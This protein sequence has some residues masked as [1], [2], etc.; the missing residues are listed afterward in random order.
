[1]E[2]STKSKGSLTSRVITAGSWTMAGYAIGQFLRLGSNLIMT[3]LL[4]PEMFGLLALTQVFLYIVGLISD[5]GIKPS[6]ITSKRGEEPAF[7]N[8]AWTI[9]IIRGFFMMGG[10]IL[11][12]LIIAYLT[13]V[14]FFVEGSVYANEDFPLILSVMSVTLLIGGFNS[15][16]IYLA[17]RKLQLGRLTIIGLVSQVAGLAIM[18]GWALYDRSVWA[19]VA[20]A[21]STAIIFTTLTHFGFSGG[22]SRFH[23][24]WDAFWEIFHFGKWI[25]VSSV[26]TAFY[27]QGD[28]LF[29]GLVISA[30]MMGVYGIAFFLSSSFQGILDKIN[31]MVFFPMFSEIARVNSEKLVEYYYKVRLRTDSLAFICAGGLF[32][33]AETLIYVLYDARYHDA[34]W[35]LQ[36]L[37][38]ML[39]FTGPM[40]SSVLMFS[41]GNSK[42]NAVLKAVQLTVLSIALPVAYFQF[43]FEGALWGLV[44]VEGVSAMF[45][46]AYRARKGMLVLFYEI[47]MLPLAIIGYFAG[48]TLNQLI[49]AFM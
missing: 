3:R 20:R 37:A 19:S 5:I 8:T 47:R 28:R 7:M 15:P 38:G 4:V 17:N 33:C 43:G 36:I 22:R 9:Q 25:V 13:S 24:E 42:F 34:G 32:A 41:T 30:E 18:I 48:M 23:W 27:L 44:L 16:N 49:L 46:M 10:V 31:N 45:D 6:V 40:I 11:V 29:L 26:I 14:G 35:M 12:A 2:N 39:L 21:V 1:M